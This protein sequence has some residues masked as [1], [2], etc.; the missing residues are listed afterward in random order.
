[1]FN[2]KLIPMLRLFFLLLSLLPM[3]LM[4]NQLAD[5]YIAKYK[6]IAISEMHRT[7]IPASIKLA[8][9][10]LESD[11]GRSKLAVEGNNHF[12]IKCGN[13]WD[14]PGFYR[15]DDDKNARGELVK[16]CFR[17]YSSVY[18][19]YIAHS[20]FLTDPKKIRRYGFLFEKETTDYK[21]WAKG[22]RKSGYATDKKYSSKLIKII[23]Q[24]EL[25]HFD[26]KVESQTLLAESKQPAKRENDLDSGTKPKSMNKNGIKRING[27]SYVLA[28]E[29]DTPISIAESY[30]CSLKSVIGYNEAISHSKQQLEDGE[31][32]FLQQKKKQFNGALKDHKVRRGEQ[33]YDIA[34]KY[35]VKLNSLYAQ[36]RMPD[37]AEPLVGEKI[38]LKGYVQWGKRP[39][40]HFPSQSADDEY[41]FGEED[42]RQSLTYSEK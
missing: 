36:N 28:N 5:V 16:S 30:G 39:D 8:Q 27:S 31:R 37:E 24:Y 18:E 3:Q 41:L 35:G 29:G 22:L 6:E 34:Q 4:A 11:W 14:G 33:M 13:N 15:F 21:G 19:S 26:Q 12:G 20:D 17:V 10:L 40:F 1:M 42:L 7:G 25:Y 38:R 2:P 23:E 32:V 9:G